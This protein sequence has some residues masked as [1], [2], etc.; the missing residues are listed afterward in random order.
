MKRK[1]KVRTGLGIAAAGLAAGAIYFT[2]IQIPSNDFS[3]EAW[4]PQGPACQNSQW[5][6][7]CTRFTMIADLKD[8]HPVGSSATEAFEALTHPDEVL[9]AV[10]R[11]L[12]V[13]ML[14]ALSQ[15]LEDLAG[16]EARGDDEALAEMGEVTARYPIQH[17]STGYL[18]VTLDFADDVV[19]SYEV[20]SP[21]VDTG[22]Y[23]EQRAMWAS[24]T[25]GAIPF[26]PAAWR[27]QGEAC[28]S[29]GAECTRARM[30]ADL[31]DSQGPAMYFGNWTR[32]RIEA[33][34]GPGVK[35]PRDYMGMAYPIGNGETL[36]AVFAPGGTVRY[37]NTTR[38]W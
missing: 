32:E 20:K 26:D 1:I 9:N 2:Q 16:S 3:A 13:A 22:W 35:P 30:I 37:L 25:E 6:R 31:V 10:A 12:G 14:G 7:A 36:F 17:Y 33:L 38:G 28:A 19:I 5:V 8:R 11:S 15:T 23:A 29:G 18:Y 21:P 34:L 24:F 4:Q 27:A